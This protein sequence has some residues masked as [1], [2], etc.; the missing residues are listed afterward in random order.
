MNTR[1]LDHRV[2]AEIQKIAPYAIARGWASETLWEQK[3][4][5]IVD[6]E[7]RPGLAACMKPGDKITAVT[8]DYIEICREERRTRFYHPDRS[9]PWKIYIR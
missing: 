7:N 4:W 9:F 1:Q 3:F 8:E 2:K 6:G 5:N